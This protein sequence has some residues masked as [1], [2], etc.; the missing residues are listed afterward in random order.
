MIDPWLFAAFCLI[1]LSVFAILR[2]FFRPA[3]DDRFVAVNTAITLA[4]AA[5]LSLSI[6]RGNIVILDISIL[7]ITLCYAGIFIMARLKKGEKV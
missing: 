4:A 2:V 7:L 3:L 5:S 6:S 1:I